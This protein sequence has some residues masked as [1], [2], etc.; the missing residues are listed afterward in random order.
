MPNMGISIQDYLRKINSRLTWFDIISLSLSLL[1]LGLTVA[2]LQMKESSNMKEIIYKKGSYDI[3]I[4]EEGSDKGD[5][6]FGSRKGKTYTF[7][8]CKGGRVIK[9]SNKIYFGSEE[10]A[11]STGRTLSKLCKK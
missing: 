9:E 4:S 10:E 7:S 8:W 5:K 3:S 6:P 11:K 1:V 2:F